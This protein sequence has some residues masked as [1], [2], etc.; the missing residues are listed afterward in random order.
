[1]MY[2]KNAYLQPRL[3]VAISLFALGACGT[4]GRQHLRSLAPADVVMLAS[5]GRRE[6][7]SLFGAYQP[8][9][10][11]GWQLDIIAWSHPEGTTAALPII[12]LRTPRSGP[13][14]WFFTGIHGEEPAGPNAMA[15]VV[16]RLASLGRRQP[17]VIVPLCNPHGYVRSWRYLNMA[18]YDPAIAGQSVGDSSHWLARAD[19]LTRPREVAPSSLEAAALT[20]YVVTTA[21]RYPPRVSIDLH[22]DNLIDEGYVYSQGRLGQV[23]PLAQAAV[24]VL[25]DKGIPIRQSGTTRFGEA[26]SG[27][28]IGPVVDSSIDELMSAGSLVRDGHSIAGPNA[29]TVLVFETP[30]RAL[31]L[32]TRVAAHRALL[33][34]LIDDLAAQERR[35]PSQWAN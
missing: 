21:A 1:M 3:I 30:A 4:V 31:P 5:D 22:E 32:T 20:Q 17:V 18:Q 9:L 29:G 24:A 28:L 16:Q 2:R 23:D 25:R 14:T 35:R 15:G 6:I 10:D 27:G 13:A 7:H 33:E 11:Q 26:I 8:L 12:A 34:R 19:E